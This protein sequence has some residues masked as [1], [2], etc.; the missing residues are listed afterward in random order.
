MLSLF[1]QP[2]LTGN[3]IDSNWLSLLTISVGLTFAI[4]GLCY[5]EVSKKI[6][7]IQMHEV[8]QLMTERERQMANRFRYYTAAQHNWIREAGLSLLTIIPVFA[9]VVVFCFEFL[10][11]IDSWVKI[12]QSL[13]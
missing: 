13:M 10:L 6:Q 11:K 1:L 9:W 4:V 12:F 3:S 7:D 5:R 8:K 2:V